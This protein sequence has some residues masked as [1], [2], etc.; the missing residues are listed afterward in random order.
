MNVIVNRTTTS[1][2]LKQLTTFSMCNSLHRIENIHP[3]QVQYIRCN[4]GILYPISDVEYSIT[5]EKVPKN[6]SY[7]QAILN[8]ARD[9]KELCNSKAVCKNGRTPYSGVIPGDHWVP[10]SDSSNEWVQIGKHVTFKIVQFD[11]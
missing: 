6:I 7:Q 2:Y 1:I 4:H 10:V 11:I 9:E 8:C 3:L 5:V